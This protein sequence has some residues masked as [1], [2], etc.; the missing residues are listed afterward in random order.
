MFLLEGTT[1][2]LKGIQA[3]RRE[4][5]RNLEEEKKKKKSRQYRMVLEKTGDS[6]RS[7][8]TVTTLFVF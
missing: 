5:V 7:Q 8:I 3:G 2:I 4:D 1:N 6:G